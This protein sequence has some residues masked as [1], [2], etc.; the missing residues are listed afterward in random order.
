MPITRRGFLSGTGAAA[1][2][3]QSL[4]LA[5]AEIPAAPNAPAK[6]WN[7]LV[8]VADDMRFDAMG[9]MLNRVVRTPNLDALAERGLL[10]VNHFV[11][12]SICPTSRASIYL[13][14]YAHRHGIWDFRRPMS[15]RQFEQSYFNQ[16]RDTHKVGFIGK[17][18]LMEPAPAD[19]FDYW[20]GYAGQGSYFET[21]EHKDRHLT[22]RQTDRAVAFVAGALREKKLF[23]LTLCYK[24]PHPQDGQ[25]N[26]FQPAAEFADWYKDVTMPRPA[27]ATESHF[28]RLPEF[29]RDSE[30]RKRWKKRFGDEESFQATVRDYY[31][32]I[33]GI[34]ASVGMI[35][36]ELRKL[37]QLDDTLIVFTSD[38]G[39]M[40]GEHGLAG[41]WWMFEESIRVPLLICPPRPLGLP[42]GRM[43][44]ATSLNVDIH[45]TLL[46]AFGKDAPPQ[47][48]GRNL[49][50]VIEGKEAGV[51]EDFYYELFFKHPTIAKTE[52]VR[53]RTWKYISWPGHKEHG[54]MLFNLV[55]DPQEETDLAGDPA[56][57]QRKAELRARML[58]L[59]RQ[60][61]A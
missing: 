24:A 46:G 22:M 50:P 3:S 42:V 10:F 15:A 2:S 12:T 27:T 17:W 39:F 9:A 56:H 11:T 54:E 1:A 19:R 31:R 33:S 55:E 61:D 28:E 37:G 34:D 40:F 6:N 47:C 59:K 48:Q 60:L 8:L 49:W 53:T 5:R 32:L 7:V 26:E 38:N 13:G 29:L 58:E 51:R 45:P 35:I 43:L 25:A 57:A 14:Q 18:G 30:A 23:A 36:D 21:P 52:G 41:K 4:S 44:T 20:A 16:L